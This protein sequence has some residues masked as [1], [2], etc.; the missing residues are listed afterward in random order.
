[1]LLLTFLDELN[2]CRVAR[3]ASILT[4]AACSTI[5]GPEDNRVD[6][7]VQSEMGCCREQRHGREGVWL[8]TRKCRVGRSGWTCHG[9]SIRLCPS[10]GRRLDLHVQG[11]LTTQSHLLSDLVLRPMARFQIS[12]YCIRG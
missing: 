5:H 11:E 8:W 12:P 4:L 9:I 10:T 1:M 3:V 7:F 2:M 6:S